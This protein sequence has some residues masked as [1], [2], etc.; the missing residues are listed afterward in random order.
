MTLLLLCCLDGSFK[1]ADIVQ[2][3]EDT[4]Y[5]DTVGDGLLYEVLNQIVGIVTV[6][7]HVLS[8]EQHLELS[9]RHFLSQD[10]QSFPRILVQEANA[11]IECSAAPALSRV[12][13]DLV[14]LGKDRTHVVHRHSCGEQ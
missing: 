13:S 6:A 11:G 2:C 9:I 7:Q 8:S 5:V 1:V 4:D 3:V 12:E 14:H 10:T